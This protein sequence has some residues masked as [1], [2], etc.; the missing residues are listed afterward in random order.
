MGVTA[1]GFQGPL[2]SYDPKRAHIR[3]N[4]IFVNSNNG[5]LRMVMAVMGQG[6]EGHGRVGG[7]KK[8]AGKHQFL[9][10]SLRVQREQ[11]HPK[12]SGFD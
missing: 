5:Q 6:P 7:S 3:S 9:S 4:T 10:F 12:Q 1:P 2:K 11:N 8:R